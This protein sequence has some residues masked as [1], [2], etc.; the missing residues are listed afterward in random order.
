M[1]VWRELILGYRKKHS[2]T[3]ADAAARLNVS[4]QTISRWESGKQEPD[5][6]AQTTLREALGM[7]SLTM[8]DTWIQRVSLSAG[9]E[10]LFEAG[11][12]CIALSPKLVDDEISMDPSIIGKSLFDVAFF[13]PLRP[14]L[15]GA[16]LFTGE[17]RMARL[18]AEFHLKDRSVGRIFD[19][20]PVLTGTDE[21]LVHAVAYPYPVERAPGQEPVVAVTEFTTLPR[22]ESSEPAHLEKSRK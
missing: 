3:Q 20:W 11:W 18:K 5:P 15:E 7:L 16:G 12:R 1:S 22:Q 6:A 19:L 17:N 10:H 21:I 4:Q 2:F 9:R 13:A 14:S 8:R